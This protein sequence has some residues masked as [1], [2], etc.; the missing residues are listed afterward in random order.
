VNAHPDHRQFLLGDSTL[1]ESLKKA[2]EYPFHFYAISRYA[3]ERKGEMDLFATMNNHD[4]TINQVGLSG[5][6]VMPITAG[7]GT[8]LVT[9]STAIKATTIGTWV[10]PAGEVV[11]HWVGGAAVGW[12][13]SYLLPFVGGTM[14][15]G[16]GGYALYKYLYR[17]D[18][19]QDLRR[20]NNPSMTGTLINGTGVTLPFARWN[21]L[22]L[23]LRCSAN[24]TVDP[25]DL[26]AFGLKR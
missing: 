3:Y 13:V 18:T 11:G 24:Y 23:E 12:T 25:W 4:D 2:L 9:A 26:Y 22:P 20:F 10:A 14:S 16:A 15:V 17:Q 21:E 1:E 6:N 7:V 8:L 19:N 5:N